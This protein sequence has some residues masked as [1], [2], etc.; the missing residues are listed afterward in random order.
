M[1]ALSV[2]ISAM[3]SPFLTSSPSCFSQRAIVPA[4]MVSLRRGMTTSVDILHSLTL[5]RHGASPINDVVELRQGLVLQRLRIGQ[6]HFLACDALYRM[7]QIVERE[8]LNLGG[9]LRACSVFA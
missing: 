2:S 5:A 6:G 1:L 4:S 9:N 7:V 8:F 3:T